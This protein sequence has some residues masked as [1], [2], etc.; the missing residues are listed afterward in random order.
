MVP[1]QAQLEAA[2]ASP[3]NGAVDRERL[4][5]RLFV[6]ALV[7][8]LFPSKVLAFGIPLSLSMWWLL[9]AGSRVSERRALAISAG[10]VVLG[11]FYWS[12]PREFIASNY[13]NSIVAYSSFLPVLMIDNRDICG[14]RLVHRMLAAV[15][16][17][18]VV[19][20]AWGIVQAIHGATQTGGF[21][22]DNGDFVSGTIHPQLTAERAAGNPFFAVNMAIMLLCSVA[23]PS[24]RATPLRR[25]SLALGSVALVLA[26]VMHVLVFVVVACALAV[27]AVARRGAPEAPRGQSRRLWLVIA[28]IA[29]LAYTVMRTEVDLIGSYVETAANVDALKTP[30]AMLLHRVT[31]ELGV[32]APWQPWIGLGPGQF[33]SR[34]SL[35]ATGYYLGTNENPRGVPFLPAR[36]TSLTSEYCL[37]LLFVMKAATDNAIGSSEQPFFSWLSIYTESGGVAVLALLIL[38]ARIVAKL[39]RRAMQHPAWGPRAMVVIAGTLFFALI[40][41]QDTYWEVPQ[42][43]LIGLLLLKAMYANMMYGAPESEAV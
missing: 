31:N 26:S 20:G 36:A 43:I 16:V 24:G 42:A 28:I 19:Q 9:Q 40:G 14:P 34:G 33:C 3:S 5:H 15:A 11:V 23:L 37:P 30:R 6:V 22:G 39:R 8:C 17:M 27:L 38:L 2:I 13:V 1:D 18:L 4:Y 41:L 29:G 21:G 10:L 32:E 35:V 25:A 7:G 12:V